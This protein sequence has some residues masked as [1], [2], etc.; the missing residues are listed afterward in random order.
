MRSLR[1]RPD[2]FDARTKFTQNKPADVIDNIPNATTS[3]KRN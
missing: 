3:R 1:R 2:R